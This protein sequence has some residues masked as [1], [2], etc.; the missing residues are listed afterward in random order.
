MDEKIRIGVD[1]HDPVMEFY[2]LRGGVMDGLWFKKPDGSRINV[3]CPIEGEQ[4]LKLN[5]TFKNIPL[6]PFP[7]RL[8]GG[9]YEFAGESFQFPI[10]ETDRNNN[11]H[12]FGF[13]ENYTI[14]NTVVSS[15]RVKTEL[16]YVYNGLFRFYPFPSEYVLLFEVRNDTELEVQASVVNKGQKPMPVGI[17]WHPYFTLGEDVDS[18]SLKL[19]KVKRKVMDCRALPTGE[20]EA[21]DTFSHMTTVGNIFLDDC[22][23]LV[24]Q[25]PRASAVIWSPVQQLGIEVWQEAGDGQYRYMQ[26]FTHPSRKRIAVEPM[27]C[28]V[29]AFQNGEGLKILQPGERFSAKFGVRLITSI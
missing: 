16:K 11:L 13:N 25:E 8:D 23:E 21:F 24:E 7:N 28:N 18:L 20:S 22:F 27:T 15:Q 14:E 29:N 3:L 26:V 6:F 9:K 17:G 2:P 1:Q 4:D 19:P 5:P 12:G 10:N